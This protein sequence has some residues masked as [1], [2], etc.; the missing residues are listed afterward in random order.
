MKRFETVDAYI[1]G[2]ENWQNELR[3]LRKILKATVL[4]ETVKWG[5]PCYTHGGKNLVG[6]GAFKSYVGLWF[7]QGAL[8]SDPGDVLINAQEGRTKAMR[9]WRFESDR[10]IKTRLIKA[11]VSEAVT[12]QDQ[13]VEIKPMK[14]KSLDLPVELAD[15]LEKNRVAAK[16]FDV[17]TMGRQREYADYIASAKRDETKLKRLTKI[18][19]M[20]ESR[21]GLNDKYRKC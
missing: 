13:G 3:Q 4:K 12:L 18:L 14:G 8:L 15:A 1:E 6:L 10:D 17:L 9:Q 5:A 2:A 7:F 11:Y 20:I 21:Q 19:P 16:G